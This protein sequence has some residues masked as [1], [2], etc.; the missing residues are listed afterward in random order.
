MNRINSKNKIINYPKDSQ[1]IDTSSD[2]SQ[3]KKKLKKK[4]TS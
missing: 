4:Q 2:S 3:K 1:D